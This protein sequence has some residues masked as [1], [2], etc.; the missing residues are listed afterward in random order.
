[1][2]KILFYLML[3]AVAFVGCSEK[4]TYVP[5]EPVDGAQ[6]FFP[7]G[8]ETKYKINETVESLELIV[9]RVEK[10]VESSVII[11]VTDTSKTFFE[12]G[13]G[14]LEASFE[15]GSDQTSITIPVDISKYEFG[16]LLGLDLEITDET[17]GKRYQG[18]AF[19]PF[20]QNII[21]AGGLV[22]YVNNK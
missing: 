8:T 18:Q 21:N 4:D 13:L 7:L 10:E 22:N 1:M 20:M 15:A 11:E 12:S 3:A 6:Y 14:E 17:T 2:K 9:K 19:P 16:D 5:A